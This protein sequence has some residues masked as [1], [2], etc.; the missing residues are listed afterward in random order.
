MKQYKPNKNFKT[1]LIIIALILIN[2]TVIY[3]SRYLTSYTMV[4]LIKLLLILLDL[5][6]SYY[7]ISTFTIRYMINDNFILINSFFGLRKVKITFEDIIGYK[8]ISSEKEMQG[9][10]LSGFA[11]KDIAM[12]RAFLEKLGL[13]RM[14]ITSNKNVVVILT[15][16]INYAIT[17][18]KTEKIINF[19][20]SKGI[21]ELSVSNL[22]NK[23]K[24][25]LHN[26]KVFM[27]PLICSTIICF[28][29]VI[30]PFI[31]Y[32]KG[33][34]HNIMPLSFDVNF[35][36]TRT[37]TGKQFA[38]QQMMYGALNMALIFCMYFAAH[39]NAKYDKKSAYKFIYIALII[40]VTFLILQ[41]KIL[42]V[43][44]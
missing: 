21:V 25:S 5:Y 10:K 7:I 1:F 15:K 4:I 20:E 30:F 9:I 17:P 3:L 11:F 28:A 39:F 12:G 16:E 24:V 27:I 22:K 18:E 26:D 38:F 44:L 13:T 6:E 36:P 43:Y 42:A 40:S 8:K 35:N 2:I 31:L 41:F 19:L 33:K 34:L 32:L 23:R 29:L 37:G 14:Y